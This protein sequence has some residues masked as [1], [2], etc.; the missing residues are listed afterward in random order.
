MARADGAYPA[1]AESG[2]TQP[3]AALR[4]HDTAHRALK[5]RD[6]ARIETIAY[7]DHERLIVEPCAVAT[8]ELR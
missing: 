3:I 4:R 2:F 5:L 7:D 6:L 8:H 1:D